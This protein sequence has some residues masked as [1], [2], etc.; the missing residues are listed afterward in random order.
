MTTTDHGPDLTGH[1][2]SISQAE[3]PTDAL[4]FATRAGRNYL[5]WIAND[6]AHHNGRYTPSDPQMNLYY[7][8]SST[9]VGA[10][11]ITHGQELYNDMQRA[12]YY[13]PMPRIRVSALITEQKSFQATLDYW[14][15]AHN[16]PHDPGTHCWDIGTI[17][18]LGIRKE[19][20]PVDVVMDRF[21]A[22]ATMTEHR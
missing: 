2:E 18:G 6:V 9:I 21:I 22:M 19:P 17:I 20:L 5:R 1:V 7:L 3:R 15:K 12:K 8:L 10:E 13:K 4:P 14:V 16:L 11:Y